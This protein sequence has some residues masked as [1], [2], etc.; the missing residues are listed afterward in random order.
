MDIKNA[1]FD[2]DYDTI[3]KAAKQFTRSRE[4]VINEKV[5]EKWYRI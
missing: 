5:M 3:E 2:A 1:Y 4:K